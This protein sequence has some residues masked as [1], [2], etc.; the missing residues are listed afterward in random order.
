MMTL[1]TLQLLAGVEVEHINLQITPQ[2][3]TLDG[4]EGHGT[5]SP[6]SAR[7]ELLPPGMDRGPK[8]KGIFSM[9]DDE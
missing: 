6:A 5:A 4:S 3:P 7:D 8:V 2:L 1:V 9:A